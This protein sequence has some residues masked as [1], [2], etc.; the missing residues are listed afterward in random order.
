MSA[1]PSIVR[2]SVEVMST[3]PVR[4]PDPLGDIVLRSTASV[5]SSR[6][7]SVARHPTAAV[8][9]RAAILDGARKAVAADGT[10]ITVAQVAARAGVAKATV[11]NHFRDL[12]DILAAVLLDEIEILIGAV[13]HLELSEALRRAGAAVSEHPLLEALGGQDTVTLAVLARIDVRSPG[14]ARVAVATETVLNRSGR[15]GSPMVLRWLSSFV[16]APAE[17]RDIAADVEILMAGLPPV[18]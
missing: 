3:H 6:A 5:S 1:V 17:G 12:Q 9:S 13:S 18:R 16:I 14:W 15:R 10:K 8:R 7:A 11:Y 4:R 2:P